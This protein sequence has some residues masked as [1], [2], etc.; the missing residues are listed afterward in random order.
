VEANLNV[1]AGARRECQEWK[2]V[3]LQAYQRTRYL[4]TASR[5]PDGKVCLNELGELAVTKF[6]VEPVPC[7]LQKS[8]H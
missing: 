3:C 5:I 7:T 6:A 4:L 2:I 1:A 8:A